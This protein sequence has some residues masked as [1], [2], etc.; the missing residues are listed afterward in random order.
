MQGNTRTV[1]TFRLHL[2]LTTSMVTLAFIAAIAL[3][4][5]LPLAAHL[6]QTGVTTGAAPGVAEHFLYLHSAFWPVAF[7][8]LVGC[9]VSG[10]ILYNKMVGPLVQFMRVFSTISSGECPD[11]IRIR[12]T[13]YLGPQTAALNAMIRAI[14]EQR[15]RRSAAHRRISEIAEELVSEASDG[16]RANELL[17]ELRSLKDLV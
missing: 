11:E 16:Q 15:E 4:L 9:I 17:E 1:N 13:D 3:S 5:F 6:D 12:R 8:S 10:L 7:C 14:R 2:L